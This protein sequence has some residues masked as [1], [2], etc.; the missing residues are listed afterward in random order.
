MHEQIAT[1]IRLRTKQGFRPTILAVILIGDNAA[2][3]IYVRNIPTV[4]KNTDIN[5]LRTETRL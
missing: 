5:F 4:L 1:D 3:E 2:S